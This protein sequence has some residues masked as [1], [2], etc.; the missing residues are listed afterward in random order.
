MTAIILDTE[1]ADFKGPLIELAW[2]NIQTGETF[3]QRYNPARKI[4]PRATDVHHIRDEDVADQPHHLTVSI[5]RD[6]EYIIGHNISFD[7]RM[8]ACSGV[9]VSRFK[10]VC[11]LELARKAFPEFAS[12]KLGALIDELFDPDF[13]RQVSKNAHSALADVR[14]TELLLDKI[15][16][17]MS[18]TKDIAQIHAMTA[19]VGIP[20]RISFGKHKGMLLS[21][22]PLDYVAWLLKQS[23]LDSD[24]RKGLKGVS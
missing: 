16:E 11:T 8:L 9:D 14:M 6:V 19:S 21:D 18:W 24:L 20:M 4:H 1:T 7:M 12:Y 17:R 2:L 23:N 5:P 22:L 13:A 15:I 3:Q 10:T